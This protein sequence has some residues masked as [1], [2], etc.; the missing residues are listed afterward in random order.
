MLVSTRFIERWSVRIVES[1]RILFA[2][3][4]DVVG[5]VQFREPSRNFNSTL[6]LKIL[7]SL[8]N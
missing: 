8:N 3:P 1:S 6:A 2:K 5:R 7:S 4:N